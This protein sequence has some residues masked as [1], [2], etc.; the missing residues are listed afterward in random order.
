MVVAE[1]LA[2]EVPVI[3][4]RGAPWECLRDEGCGWWTEIS[5]DGLR[6]ALREAT[7]SAAERLSEMGRRGRIMVAGRFQWTPIARRV[8]EIYSELCLR[9][10]SESEAAR[11]A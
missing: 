9:R 2:H 1:A 4:T 6:E 7:S 8:I 10:A 3:T 11:A 5:V